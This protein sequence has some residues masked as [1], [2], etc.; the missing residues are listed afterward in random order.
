LEA[1]HSVG[2]FSVIG[3]GIP[4]D[5]IDQ[6]FQVSAEFFSQP[7]D[8]KEKQ[9]PFAKELNAGYEYFSQVRPSTGT[10]DQKESLQIT[11]REGAMDG[12]WPKTPD[13]FQ[14]I[15]NQLMVEAHKLAC[16]VLDLLEKDACP[17]NQPGDLSRSHKLWASDGQC[18]LRMLHYPPMDAD[19]AKR[20]TTPD[21]EGRI[22]WRAG[23]HTDWYVMLRNTFQRL[24]RALCLISHA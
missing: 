4:L 23:P 19:T 10:T 11:A 13:N 15:S 7:Q 20:L 12:R 21:E 5:L 24:V 2:F 6:A 3:H 14:E 16:R 18:T 8:S 22:H 9:S 17:M 1:A